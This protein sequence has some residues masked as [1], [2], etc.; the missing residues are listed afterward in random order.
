MYLWIWYRKASFSSCFNLCP[1]GFMSWC[2]TDFTKLPKPYRI[3]D[4]EKQVNCIIDNLT[5][6]KVYHL[7][8]HE[9][10]K[11]LCYLPES[12]TLCLIDFDIAL[13]QSEENKY[14]VLSKNL[15]NYNNPSYRKVIMKKNQTNFRNLSVIFSK[16]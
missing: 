11:N 13:L 10:G 15:K 6:A 5:R 3:P 4:V 12:Q 7:D 1:E 8:Y 16:K 14:P 2:G 9:S